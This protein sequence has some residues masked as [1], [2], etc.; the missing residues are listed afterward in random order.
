M[1]CR[2]VAQELGSGGRLD[3]LFAGTPSLMVATLSMHKIALYSIHL[4]VLDVA[5]AFL[6]GK[7]RRMI[8]IALPG[9]DP[10]LKSRSKMGRLAQAMY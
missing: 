8:Y 6:Y 1:R 3:E 9:Q 2:L 10:E 4:I 7:L 5:C